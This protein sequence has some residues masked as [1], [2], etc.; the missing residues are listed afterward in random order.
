MFQLGIVPSASSLTKLI[1]GN[2]IN[3]HK[4]SI[5]DVV[6]KINDLT[7]DKD[8]MMQLVIQ[9]VEEKANLDVV[10]KL[11]LKDFKSKQEL[12]QY[13]TSNSYTLPLR[14]D[15][16]KY[17]SYGTYSEDKTIKHF[18]YQPNRPYI[19]SE[20]RTMN[21]AKLF[22]IPFLTMNFDGMELALDE[23]NNRVINNIIEVKST[24]KNLELADKEELQ[25]NFL[26]S[27]YLQTALYANV[28][29]PKEGVEVLY[30]INNKDASIKY[31]SFKIDINKLKDKDFISALKMFY[32]E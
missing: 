26:N 24:I 22:D 17:L 14:N 31:K 4:L 2:S 6:K 13:L 28:I 29:Q 21:I 18:N 7:F 32:K 27:Y 19:A 30:H 23:N 1:L 10:S 12:E 5:K 11:E 16:N 15:A 8:K 25:A 3:N 20:K 9:R